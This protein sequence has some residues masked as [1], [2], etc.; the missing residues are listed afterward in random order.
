M[1]IR[2]GLKECS[3][4]HQWL[5]YK[6]D[7]LYLGTL[8]SSLVLFNTRVYFSLNSK[9]KVITKYVRKYMLASIIVMMWDNPELENCK[10]LD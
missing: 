5:V 2:V 4:D 1:V 7:I 8:S 3:M 9:F 10:Y 6:V